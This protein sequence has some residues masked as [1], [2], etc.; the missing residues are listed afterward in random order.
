MRPVE[1][2]GDAELLAELLPSRRATRV[3]EV[4]DLALRDLVAMAPDQ[5]RS[6]YRLTP[7]AAR[8]LGL[9]SE[10]HR[11]L[12]TYRVPS[13][14]SLTTPEAVHA[15]MAPLLAAEEVETFY[16]L[17]L[18]ARSR[19]IGS[20]RRISQG[21]CDGTDAGPRAFFRAVVRA[22][23]V[24]AIAVHN[25]PSGDPEPSPADSA[26]TKRLVQAGRSIDVPLVDHVVVTGLRFRS[27]RRIHPGLWA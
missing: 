11:R 19:L 15:L 13:R 17:P 7:T 4:V 3:G 27:L 10:I 1:Q 8:R 23:A 25:H 12:V 20:P 14:P 6:S 26:V 24:S 9:V 22:G 18:D 16:A 21:D 5:L 2:L